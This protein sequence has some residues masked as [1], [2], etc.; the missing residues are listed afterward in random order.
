MS[1]RDPKPPT[2]V[3]P[4]IAWPDAKTAPVAVP[5]ELLEQC[6]REEPAPTTPFDGVPV[7]L[8]SPA[9][10]PSRG[11]GA[12]STG[13]FGLDDLLSATG[14][15]LLLGDPFDVVSTT[16]VS[17]TTSSDD[18]VEET[19]TTS[20]LVGRDIE[21]MLGPTTV[22][23]ANPQRPVV[24]LST[25]EQ[26]VFSQLDGVRAIEG[27]AAAT[28]LSIGDL[29]IALALLADKDQ[30]VALTPPAPAPAT[31]RPTTTTTK[32][33]NSPWDV[34]ATPAATVRSVSRTFAPITV[35]RRIHGV[36]ADGLSALEGFVLGNV[37]GTRSVSQLREHM[38]L[39]ESDL[40]LALELLQRRGLVERASQLPKTTAPLPTVT[41]ST[42]T[43]TTSNSSSSSSK[44]TPLAALLMTAERKE[45]RGDLA[46]SIACLQQAVRIEPKNAA[47]WN[48]LGTSLVRQHELPAALAALNTALALSPTDPTITSNQ[49]R[50]ALLAA[51]V[52]RSPKR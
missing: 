4:P 33:T 26:F 22:L 7:N 40:A 19:V 50:V 21:R 32:Q 14:D 16:V 13:K 23:A 48:R 44:E 6:M 34:P 8:V 36:P 31:T 52:V 37:D 25:F 51:Q 30:L 41:T 38:K 9:A 49:K 27:V 42:T 15:V 17:T 12:E 5:F 47:L 46:G 11:F 24:E 29:R 39:S 1:E 2:S 10:T 20:I 3:P 35:L 18:G 28:G 45:A 43:V